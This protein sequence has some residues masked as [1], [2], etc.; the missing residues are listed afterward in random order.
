MPEPISLCNRSFDLDWMFRGR[1]ETVE[2][3]LVG[4]AQS[5]RVKVTRGIRRSFNLL[6]GQGGR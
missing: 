3:S 1:M 4:E 2:A 6:A 5:T